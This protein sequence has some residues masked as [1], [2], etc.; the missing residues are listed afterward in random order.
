MWSPPHLG[1][2]RCQRLLVFSGLGKGVVQSGAGGAALGVDLATNLTGALGHLFTNP[3]GHPDPQKIRVRR[4][5]HR[6]GVIEEW[7]EARAHGQD[8]LD[9]VRVHQQKHLKAMHKKRRANGPGLS[10][11]EYYNVS[12][13]RS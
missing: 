2:R 1:F 8:M 10:N 13:R 5:V 9:T 3:L 4:V 11:T 6:G 12:C 7:N